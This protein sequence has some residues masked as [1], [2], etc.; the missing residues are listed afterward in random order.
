LALSDPLNKNFPLSNIKITVEGQICTIGGASTLSALVCTLAKNAV[1]NPLL[2]AGQLTPLVYIKDIG[3]V[4]L[5]NGVSP[6]SVNLATTSLT[7]TSG[8]NNGGY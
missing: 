5:A 7:K 2:V 1:N 8:G 6:L 3:I 4:K